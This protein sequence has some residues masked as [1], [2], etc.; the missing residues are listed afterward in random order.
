MMAN[1][2]PRP[3]WEGGPQCQNYF[4]IDCKLLFAIFTV[5]MFALMEQEQW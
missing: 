4:Q 1:E 2:S 5:L 3:F